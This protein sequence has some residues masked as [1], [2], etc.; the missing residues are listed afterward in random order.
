ML[1]LPATFGYSEGG[2]RMTDGD[3][4]PSLAE[5]RAHPGAEQWAKRVVARLLPDRAATGEPEP[6]LQPGS[7]AFTIGGVD[8]GEVLDRGPATRRDAEVVSVLLLIGLER[9]L[10]GAEVPLPLTAE[11]VRLSADGPYDQLGS[12]DAVLGS[13]SAGV[14]RAVARVAEGS[15][16]NRASPAE[17]SVALAALAASRLPTARSLAVALGSRH[18][19]PVVRRAA[20]TAVGPPGLT[21]EFARGPRSALATVILGVTGWLFLSAAARLLGRLALGLRRP[22]E[23]AVSDRGLELCQKTLLLGRVLRERRTLVTRDGVARV[24]REVRYTRAALYAGLIALA[25]GTYVGMGLLLDGARVPGT[26]PSLI[27]LG[28]LAVAIGLALD[29]GLT[30]L[31]DLA[32]GRCRLLLVPVRGRPFGVSGLDPGEADALLRRLAADLALREVGGVAAG[33]AVEPPA[34]ETHHSAPDTDE[35]ESP[36]PARAEPSPG[37]APARAEPEEPDESPVKPAIPEGP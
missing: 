26:S 31:S 17:A 37:A 21:G 10:G 28:L 29:F 13:A 8:V 19:S 16:S 9:E 2:Q 3:P 11:L 15:G 22:A 4:M 1:A 23:L 12:V 30:W 32:R 36:A 35:P 20:A 5:L 25:L 33:A 34:D 7:T 24:I 27:G 18:A 6:P 14:W